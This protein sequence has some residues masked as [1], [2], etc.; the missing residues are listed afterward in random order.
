MFLP[1]LVFSFIIIAAILLIFF[2]KVE[3]VFHQ[4]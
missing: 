2:V 1:I 4:Q 3:K